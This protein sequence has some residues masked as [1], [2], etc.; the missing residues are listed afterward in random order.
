MLDMLDAKRAAEIQESLL[1]HY[2]IIPRFLKILKC[3]YIDVSTKGVVAPQL[4]VVWFSADQWWERTVMFHIEDGPVLDLRQMFLKQIFAIRVGVLR[5]SA[6]ITWPDLRWRAWIGEE[7][8]NHLLNVAAKM[9][10]SPSDWYGSLTPVPRSEW[11]A[12]E[13]FNGEQWIPTAFV[14]T[15]LA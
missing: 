9:G 2:T 1:W 6:P 3:S 13:A 10:A 4:P 15:I 7:S 11:Q 8:A 14:K 5:K 12:V